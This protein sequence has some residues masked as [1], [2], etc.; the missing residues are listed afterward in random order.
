MAWMRATLA[1]TLM[2]TVWVATAAAGSAGLII[3]GKAAMALLVA[4]AREP[5]ATV[6][7]GG[8]SG[9]R[10]APRV[11]RETGRVGKEERSETLAG[12]ITHFELLQLG[13]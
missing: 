1:G 10:R 7:A 3:V 12:I 9:G 5:T 4:A 13:G 2:L 6:P 11:T 8:W